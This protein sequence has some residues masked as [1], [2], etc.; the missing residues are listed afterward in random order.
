VLAVR[1][2]T[3]GVTIMPEFGLPFPI[4]A[5]I[6]NF[7]VW[8][9]ASKPGPV[10][11]LLPHALSFATVCLLSQVRQHTRTRTDRADVADVS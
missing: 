8:Q 9:D 1:L 10:I 7:G 2:A 5:A 4:V 6:A 11:R 3:H